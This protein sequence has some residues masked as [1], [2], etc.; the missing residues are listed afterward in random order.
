MQ[1]AVRLVGLAA[2]LL[3][4]LGLG[5]LLLGGYLAWQSQSFRSTAIRT[6]GTVVSY[7][8]T[9]HDGQTRYRP[10]V[11]YVT[12]R[13]DINTSAGQMDYTSPRIPV[14]TE[15]PV[16]YQEADT[17]KMRIATFFDNWLGASIAAGVGVL[18][19][20]GGFF[21]RRQIGRAPAA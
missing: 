16:D 7:H 13:G 3:L 5:C 2:R 14:G 20:L 6:T 15:V 11:R 8:E 1:L 17:T 4:A 18:T 21:V 19:F 10:R 9:N 12:V